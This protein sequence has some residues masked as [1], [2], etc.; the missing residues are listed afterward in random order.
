LFKTKTI[1]NRTK[2]TPLTLSPYDRAM[3]YN[4]GYGNRQETVK[5][6]VA[7]NCDGKAVYY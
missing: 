4:I 2:I 7:Q 3:W 6:I 5:G 1:N